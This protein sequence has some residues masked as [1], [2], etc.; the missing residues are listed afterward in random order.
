MLLE[1]VVLGRVSCIGR[2]TLTEL[3][4]NFP[5]GVVQLSVTWIA[6]SGWS[7]QTLGDKPMCAMF[8][9]FGPL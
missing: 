6:L 7:L 2:R 4:K 5:D 9:A 1:K 3:E 8:L